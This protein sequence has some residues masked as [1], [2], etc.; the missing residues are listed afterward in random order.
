METRSNEATLLRPEGDRILNAALVE[1]DLNKFIAQLKRET[2]W[3]DSDRNS[4][5]VYKSDNT[6]IVLIGLHAG[7]ELKEHTAKGSIHVQVLDGEIK[8]TTGN[9]TAL[10]QPGQ[11]ITLQENKPHNVLA[12][13]ESFFLLTLVSL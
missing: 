10:L 7:A 3:T 9:Q 11:M 1:I 13:K 8:F 5:T 12:V 6:S 2:T 4:I